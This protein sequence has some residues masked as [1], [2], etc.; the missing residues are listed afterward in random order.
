VAIAI[1]ICLGY[2][3][4]RKRVLRKG[5]LVL[6]PGR[7]ETLVMV[8][9]ALGVAW[10]LGQYLT[11]AR[12]AKH[13][14][15]DA[16]RDL[17]EI[18]S[19]GAVVL[20]SVATT[21]CLENRLD[22]VPVYGDIMRR[23]DNAGLASYPVTHVLYREEGLR[24]FLEK[25]FPDV[26]RRQ[27][28]VRSYM[29][30]GQNCELWRVSDWPGLQGRTPRYVPS[31]FERGIALLQENRAADAIVPFEAFL[32]KFP[33]NAS[34]CIVLGA[35]YSEVGRSSEAL[36][37]FERAVNLRPNDP[38]ALDDLGDLYLRA[39]QEK[40]AEEMWSRALKLEPG[41]DDLANRLAMLRG[42]GREGFLFDEERKPPRHPSPATTPPPLF[43][44]DER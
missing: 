12:H 35:C 30:A 34:A 41:N 31:D 9:I 13:T 32:R 21:L 20:G 22:S 23:Q 5:G 7:R 36:S 24:P 10:E 3:A 8:L 28:F 44:G 38:A 1:M 29:I 16:G 17:G 6:S 39:N 4:W 26:V 37:L 18:L 11:W 14:L 25:S 33:D 15:R 43:E 19:P 27:A 2:V 40:K 42:R